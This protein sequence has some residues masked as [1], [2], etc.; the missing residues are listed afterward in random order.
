MQGVEKPVQ[1]TALGSRDCVCFDRLLDQGHLRKEEKG[2]VLK[3]HWSTTI[4]WATKCVRGE[5][6]GGKAGEERQ[7][8]KGRGGKAAGH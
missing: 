3:R 1:V 5:G 6:R 4:T 7:G 8:R 2:R